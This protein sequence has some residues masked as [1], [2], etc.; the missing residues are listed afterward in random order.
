M[1]WFAWI[2]WHINYSKFINDKSFSYIFIRKWL[3]F[4]N[5][6]QLVFFTLFNVWLISNSNIKE[7]DEKRVLFQ[8]TQF[9][10]STLFSSILAID[11]TISSGTN[12]SM[13]GPGINCHESVLWIPQSSS[14]SEA[15][16]S[17]CF[18]SY[19]GHS[20]GRLTP[21]QSCSRCILKPRLTGPYV[22]FKKVNCFNIFMWFKQ[23]P[24]ILSK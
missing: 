23:W 16:P 6:P 19:P 7:L 14:V 18:M 1:I 2:L 9:N 13:I 8:T 5:E 12:S 17:D 24:I 10:V 3:M 15:S 4:L 20:R 11:R 21:L 22:A